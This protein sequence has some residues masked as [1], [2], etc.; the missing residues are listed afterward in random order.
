[1]GRDIG[2]GLRM[3]RRLRTEP[4]LIHAEC[5]LTLAG[6]FN[7]PRPVVWRVL[8]VGSVD[9]PTVE[10]PAL[11]TGMAPVRKQEEGGLSRL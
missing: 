7:L 9:S 4:F 1:M 6:R 8:W 2:P 5:P 11:R 3:H 10:T